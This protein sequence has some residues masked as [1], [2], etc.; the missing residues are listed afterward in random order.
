M[1]QSAH[2]QAVDV[3]HGHIENSLGGEL[4]AEF[5]C[6]DCPMVHPVDLVGGVASVERSADTEGVSGDLV[7][8][9]QDSAPITSVNVTVGEA[10][11][12][13]VDRRATR[14]DVRF[15]EF[16]LAAKRRGRGNRRRRP[17][18]DSGLSITTR[19]AEL[20]AGR[21]YVDRH[22]LPCPRPLCINCRR[23]LPHRTI[24][25]GVVN[26][27]NCGKSSNIA[28]GTSDTKILYPDDFT[29][30]EREF[31]EKRGG[32][33]LSVQS[34]SAFG[35]LYLANVCGECGSVQ[36][37]WTLDVDVHHRTLLS[38]SD[39]LSEFGP[40]TNC[41][42]RSCNRHGRYYDYDG[43]GECPVCRYD[44]LAMT[45]QTG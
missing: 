31:A 12:D 28:L 13:N 45:G 34:S 4:I 42:E 18:L 7:L 44:E 36:G 17:S 41:A 21:L 24:S 15:A 33:N 3:L 16:Q 23:P 5:P 20:S 14:P 9:D 10:A 35:D 26:C 29:H 11:G 1:N 38:A 30:H 6:N 27:W 32:V 19:L 37:D 22:K 39:Q 40:C 2:E 25:I 43:G 8:F